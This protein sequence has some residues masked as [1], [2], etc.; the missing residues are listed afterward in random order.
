[1]KHLG[2]ANKTLIENQLVTLRRWSSRQPPQLGLQTPLSIQTS[3]ATGDSPRLVFA[4]LC[5]IIKEG[6]EDSRRQLLNTKPTRKD[7]EVE[8]QWNV[9]VSSPEEGQSDQ[10]KS[11]VPPPVQMETAKLMLLRNWLMNQT[12]FHRYLQRQTATLPTRR[13]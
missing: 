5:S 6:T 13:Q 7:S 8:H 1:M 11:R 4:M 2:S 12:L 10:R 3:S 9:F